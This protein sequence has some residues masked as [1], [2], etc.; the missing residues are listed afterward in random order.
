METTFLKVV[1]GIDIDDIGNL[2]D[3]LKLAFIDEKCGNLKV[4]ID[5]GELT[6]NINQ[7]KTSDVLQTYLDLHC[8][9]NAVGEG[10]SSISK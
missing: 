1:I 5:G 6:R 4:V 8:L 10:I 7:K 9:T 3:F 2:E